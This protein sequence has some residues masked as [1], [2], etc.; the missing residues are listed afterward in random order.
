MY[1]LHVSFS[2][3]YK[4]GLKLADLQV[5][6]WFF[7][8]SIGLCD[9]TVKF[10]HYISNIKIM[11]KS[12]MNFVTRSFLK[13]RP[14]VVCFSCSTWSK[15]KLIIHNF[16]QIFIEKHFANLSS[17][18]ITNSVYFFGFCFPPLSHLMTSLNS[19]REC[20]WV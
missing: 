9:I 20:E 14:K 13:S 12:W 17:R 4:G 1:I 3:F 15:D 7:F 18:D 10:L 6:N 2:I 19:R 5:P 11:M 16:A 8:F